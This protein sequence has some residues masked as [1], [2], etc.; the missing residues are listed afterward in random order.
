MGKLNVGFVG[1]YDTDFNVGFAL[2]GLKRSIET[3]EKLGKE[4]DFNFYPVRE[5]VFNRDGAVKAKK[6]LEDKKVDFVLIQNS[7][8]APGEIILPLAAMNARLGLWAVSEPTEEGPLPL[9]SFCGMNLYG[10]II[11]YYLKDYNIKFKWFF[12][13]PK[14]KLFLDRFTLTL[15]VLSGL[16]SLSQSRLALIGGIASGFYDLY[17]DERSLRSKF[18]I[19]VFNHGLDEVLQKVKE[20]KESRVAQI[21]GEIKNEGMNKN[22]EL[23]YLQKGARVYLALEEIA[24]E[25]DYQA[26]AISCWPKFQSEYQFDVCSTLGRLNQNHIVASCEGDVVSALSMLLLNYLNHQQSTLMDLVKFD[27]SDNSL[28]MWHCGPTAQCWANKERVKYSTHYIDKF[29]VINDMVFQPQPL[30][31][32]RTTQEGRE[33]LLVKGDI[34]ASNKKSYDGSRGWVG[35][36]KQKG[37]RI[38]ALDFINTI[39]IHRFPHHFPIASGELVNEL[40]EVCNWL[41][42]EPLKVIPYHNYLQT[43]Y[44]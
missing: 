19:A 39:L 9:N 42:I 36:L 22:V 35:N 40:L 41:D 2:K 17:F 38:S 43:P 18:G 10:S 7:S 4:K 8:F 6:E 12:G 11:G 28:L 25:N 34:L 44:S 21:L 23:K 26:L 13:Y 5:G 37:K 29:G 32:M 1:C 20:Y 33:M 27:T 15:K 3:L 14:D 24:K 31:I 16:K 30:T